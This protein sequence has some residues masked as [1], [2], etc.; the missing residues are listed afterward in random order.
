[1][2]VFLHIGAYVLLIMQEILLRRW[3]TL[4][5]QLAWLFH[6][7]SCIFYQFVV[8]TRFATLSY[9]ACIQPQIIIVHI[10]M[11]PST[12][13][14]GLSLTITASLI[15]IIF[16][17]M[18]HWIPQS[19]PGHSPA[20]FWLLFSPQHSFG[21]FT[22]WTTYI[23]FHDLDLVPSTVCQ[24]LRILRNPSAG[25]SLL[26]KMSMW[27]IFIFLSIGE[28]PNMVRFASPG[29]GTICWTATG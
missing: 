6:L 1:M 4:F 29:N 2:S 5:I 15:G 27:N 21:S 19:G 22:T 7:S 17:Y 25:I 16:K 11:K 13:I 10:K 12:W 20:L 14:H 18:V 8:C 28:G 26:L 9:N 3:I 24:V 23:L